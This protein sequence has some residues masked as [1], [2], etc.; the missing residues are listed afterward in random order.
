MSFQQANAG[1]NI[2]PA[3]AQPG[4]LVSW[5]NSSRNNG[6]DHIAIYVGNGQVIA[7]PKPGDSVKIQPLWGNYR[8]TRIGG[9]K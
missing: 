3:D 5:D 2:A 1:A 7:S 9:G 6:A 8:V 4:D